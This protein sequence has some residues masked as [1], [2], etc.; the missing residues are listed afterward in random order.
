MNRNPLENTTVP[1]RVRDI[2]IGTTYLR[3]YK[4][5]LS[6]LS[7]IREKRFHYAQNF[8]EIHIITF[9]YYDKLCII[10]KT[11]NRFSNDIFEI[12]HF[13]KL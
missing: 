11:D 1:F 13:E 10:H 12:M 5:S 7:V 6:L 3:H 4:P 8:P 2:V 9:G